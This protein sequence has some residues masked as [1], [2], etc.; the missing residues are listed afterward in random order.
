[1]RVPATLLAG[2]FLLVHSASAGLLGTTIDACADTTR[3]GPASANPAACDLGTAQFTTTSALVV[4]PG[5]EFT[6]GGIDFRNADFT[7]LTVS[8]IY[9]PGQGSNSPDLFIFYNLPGT[10]TGLTLL[11]PDP[12]GIETAFTATSI[13]LLITNPQCCLEDTTTVTFQIEGLEVPEPAT[14]GLIGAG[15]GLLAFWRRK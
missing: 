9:G 13:G 14:F 12:L 2:F 8:I 4:N 10:I 11:T 3:V 7:D 5:V 1:M 15:L 6:D